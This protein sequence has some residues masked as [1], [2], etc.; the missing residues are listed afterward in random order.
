M[1]HLKLMKLLN[2]EIFSSQDRQI[3]LK[4]LLNYLHRKIL[5]ILS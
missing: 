5:Q 2:W 4:A 3:S 1:L